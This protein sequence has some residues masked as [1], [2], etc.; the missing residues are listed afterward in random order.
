MG[1]LLN[2]Y[3]TFDGTAGEAVAFYAEVLGGEPSV[4][5]FA[6]AMGGDGPPGV[7]HAHLETPDGFTLMLSDTPPGE[8]FSRGSDMSVSLSGDDAAKLRRW[9]DR[10]SEGGEVQVPLEKQMWGDVFGACK[11]KFGVTWLVNIA[12]DAA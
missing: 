2:P 9:W 1:V 4:T 7:M 11:D 10:L 8:P 12:G 3:L 5:T 6:S